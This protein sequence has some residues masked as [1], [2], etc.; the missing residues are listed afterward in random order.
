MSDVELVISEIARSV[1]LCG[2]DD[3]FKIRRSF[4]SKNAVAAQ[5]SAAIKLVPLN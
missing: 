3:L 1:V 5:N 2:V 4:E